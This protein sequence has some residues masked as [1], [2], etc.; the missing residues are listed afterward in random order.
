MSSP[1]IWQLI[2]GDQIEAY[3]LPSGVLFHMHADAAAVARVC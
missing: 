1:K 3:N 2:D